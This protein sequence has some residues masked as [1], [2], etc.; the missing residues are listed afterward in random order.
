MLF[1][2]CKFKGKPQVRKE[3]KE[4]I[5]SAVKLETPFARCNEGRILQYIDL[6]LDETDYSVKQGVFYYR[7]RRIRINLD[8]TFL[9]KVAT[10]YINEHI[11]DFLLENLQ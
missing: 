8:D 6:L 3:F 7:S 11:N 10:E 1:K 9:A 4:S 5:L 2:Q